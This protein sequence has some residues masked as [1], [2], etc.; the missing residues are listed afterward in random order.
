MCVL[1]V[2]FE[3]CH[4]LLSFSNSFDLFEEII[5]FLQVVYSCILS[6]NL[7][8]LFFSF[9]WQDTA[10]DL[11]N[12][13]QK[14]EMINVQYQ[15]M[16]RIQG[17]VR[18]NSH[19]LTPTVTTYLSPFPLCHCTHCFPPRPNLLR[20]G[21]TYLYSGFNSLFFGALSKKSVIPPPKSCVLS[22]SS[23]SPFSLNLQLKVKKKKKD[24]VSQMCP[25][26]VVE[27]CRYFAFWSVKFTYIAPSSLPPPLSTM[28]LLLFL[29]FPESWRDKV[30]HLII[31]C[32]CPTFHFH[33]ILNL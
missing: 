15:E 5:F 32:V 4:V 1:N 10:K 30:M 12:L 13:Q 26:E 18:V 22:I 9:T 17:T 23:K 19:P 2:T 28:C 29:P 21:T 16:T 31:Y 33:P 8:L 11:N 6:S 25:P 20:V 27:V 24:V 3:H 14:Q 7:F